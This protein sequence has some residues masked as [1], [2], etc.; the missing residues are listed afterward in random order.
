[1]KEAIQSIARQRPEVLT[2]PLRD[3]G[4][5]PN[6]RLPL[7]V[8][9]RALALPAGDPAS[10][11]EQLFN[12]HHWAGAWR[13][14]IYN[15]HHYHSTA[16]EVIAV[17]AGEATVQFGGSRGTTH[18]LTP[19]DVVIIP[20]GVAHK[21]LGS[22]GDFCVVGAYPEGQDWD[23]CYGKPEERARANQNIA[24]VPLPTHDPVYGVDGI[25]LGYWAAKR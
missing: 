18:K 20:A 6:S 10:A 9:G 4:V 7:L 14:G 11:I 5:I 15:Y 1:M 2:V 24:R 13:N 8:Y 12:E 17:F 23:M 16:H 19:G 21:N 3:D 25:L 22:S